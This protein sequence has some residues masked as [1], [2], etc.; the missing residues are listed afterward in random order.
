ML[1]KQH[2]HLL[3]I[4]HHDILD[5]RYTTPYSV[6][7]V[8]IWVTHKVTHTLLQNAAELGIVLIS[9]CILCCF[10]SICCQEFLFDVVKKGKRDPAP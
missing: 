6:D 4:F 10:W 5:F 8:C 1:G 3:D 7:G 2:T 9:N